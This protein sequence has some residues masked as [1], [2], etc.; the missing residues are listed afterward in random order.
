MLT[1]E[2][3]KRAD[4]GKQ[5]ADVAEQTIRRMA[6]TTQESVQAFQQIIGATS[7]QQIGFEQVTQGMQDIRQA[8]SQTAAGTLQLEKAVANLNTQ[9]HQLR[10]AV[11]RYQL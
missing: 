11:G 5:Q 10:E 3:V 4:T 2:A 9:S 7:Q 6:D 1:E 8:A